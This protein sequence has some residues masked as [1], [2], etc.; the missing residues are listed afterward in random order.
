MRTEGQEVGAGAAA[1]EAKEAREEL[2]CPM[3]RMDTAALTGPTDRM[4][5]LG[6]EG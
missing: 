4:A 3:A 5:R 1:E 2:E 6:K